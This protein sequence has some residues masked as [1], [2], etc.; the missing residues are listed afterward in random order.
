M[1]DSAVKVRQD[2]DETKTA[3]EFD[4][5]EAALDTAVLAVMVMM[6][7]QERLHDNPVEYPSDWMISRLQDRAQALLKG[8]ELE[9]PT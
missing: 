9:K 4:K 6:A 3:F 5:D 1:T 8:E 2:Y 7:I